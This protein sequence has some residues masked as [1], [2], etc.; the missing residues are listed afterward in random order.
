MR[1]GEALIFNSDL[2]ADSTIQIVP[3]GLQMLVE[4]AI[5]HNVIVDDMPLKIEIAVE[6]GFVVV[7]NNIQKKKSVISKNE[8]LGLDNLKRRYTYLSDSSMEVIIS[9][10]EFIVKLPVIE[11]K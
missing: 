11:Q 2:P 3:H 8:P 1:F 9:E 7:K 5:K 10:N 6:E 4:N